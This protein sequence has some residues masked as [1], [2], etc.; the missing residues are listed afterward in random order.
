MEEKRDIHMELKSEQMNEMLSNPPSWIVRSGN[1]VLLIALLVLIALAWFIRYPDEIS[2]EVLVTSSQAPIELSNQS[3]I[4]LKTLNV[5]ENQEVTAGDLIAQFDVQAKQTDILKAV[6]YLEVLEKMKGHF[7]AFIPEFKEQVYLGVFQEQWAALL[8]N[9]R[10]WNNE[11]KQNTSARELAFIRKEISYREQLQLISGKKIRLSE[12]EYEMIAE[13]RAGS[14]RLAEQ[15]AISKQTLNQDMR[16]QTQAMQTVQAQREQQVQNL[17]ALNSLKKDELHLEHEARLEKLQNAVEIQK[18]LA[19]L[20]NSFQNWEK[21]AVWIAPCSG[22][23]LFNKLLQVNRFYK[24]NEASLVIVP[25][26]KGYR[27]VARISSSGAGKLKT[28]QKAFIE[29]MDYPKTEFGM[30]EGKVNSLTQ[31]DKAGKYEVQIILQHP[32]KTTYNKEIPP[33]VQLKGKVKI[34][35]KDKRLLARFFEQL[36]DLVK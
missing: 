31:M 6:H 21:H 23:V 20:R 36:T 34:I 10:L 32:L 4:Q 14:E 1:G 2:G 27:A 33:K 17:I 29:L 35:T 13:Q 16:L 7:P 19:A 9:V 3:Y 5:T 18:N 12:D 11:Y 28:G 24:A 26:G 15:R 22:R 25:E 30:L 8:F